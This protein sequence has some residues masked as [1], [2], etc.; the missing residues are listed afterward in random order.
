MLAE[1]RRP[2]GFGRLL[3]ALA[4]RE[5]ATK[6]TSFWFFAVASAVCAVAHVYGGGFQQSFETESVLVTT[7][8]LMPLNVIVVAFLGL[9]LGLRLTTSLSWEREHQTLEVLLVGPVSWSQIVISKFLVEFCVMAGLLAIYAGYLFVGQPL[10]AG[11]IGLSDLSTIAA[12]PLFILPLMATGL[13][14]SAWAGSVRGAVIFYLVAAGLMAG[15]ELLLGILKADEPTS[16]SLSS[17]YLRSGME[18]V[19]PFLAPVSPVSQIASMIRSLH[20]QGWVPAGDQLFV[21]GLTLA[22]LVAGYGMARYRGARA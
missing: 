18:A 6:L 22:L 16:M 9:V 8:P 1:M 4:R 3:F 12:A 15:F 11:V 19:S 14:V 21:L 5:L 7:D 17:L 2:P 10:G 20:G 13:L